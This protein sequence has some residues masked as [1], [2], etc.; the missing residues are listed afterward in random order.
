MCTK[1]AVLKSEEGG[2]SHLYI[3]NMEVMLQFKML[4]KYD[5]TAFPEYW[6]FETIKSFICLLCGS[7]KPMDDLYFA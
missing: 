7:E 3:S 1:L 5:Y 2:T 4:Y 6:K